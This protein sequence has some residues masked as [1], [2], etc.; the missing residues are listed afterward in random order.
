MPLLSDYALTPGIF[1]KA[2]FSNENYAE[3]RFEHLQ[4]LLLDDGLVRNLYG[5]YWLEVFNT[6]GKDLHAC[7]KNLLK[8]LRTQKRLVDSV[9]AG[10]RQPIS[11][12]DWC[13]ESL[14]SH[15]LSEL[16]GIVTTQ[17]TA[18]IYGHNQ[19][20]IAPIDQLTSSKWWTERRDTKGSISVKRSTASYLEQLKPFLE[21]ANSLMF[22]DANLDP[23]RDSYRE[24]YK[25]LEPLVKR[26]EKPLVEIHRT[27]YERNPKKEDVSF[28]AWKERFCSSELAKLVHRLKLNANVYLWKYMHDRY[29]ITNIMGIS[30]PNGFDIGRGQTRW[31]TISRKDRDDCQREFDPNSHQNKLEG[32]FKIDL[33]K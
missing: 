8:A 3:M 13:K 20:L 12:E 16:N 32:S 31:S 28:D 14:S 18:R 29:L 30:L 15:N 33:Q 21:C 10:S 17:Q 4:E 27:I 24:F 26:R 22:I 2:C 11:D 5:G 9:P 6:Q 25:I 1:E 7:G 19:P 23:T